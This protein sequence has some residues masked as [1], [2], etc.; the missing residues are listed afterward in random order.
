M[1]GYARFAFTDTSNRSLTFIPT[2][3]IVQLE[4]EVQG[5]SM[6]VDST[7]RFT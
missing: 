3:L 4:C 2:G 1:Y 5:S 7:G 6:V